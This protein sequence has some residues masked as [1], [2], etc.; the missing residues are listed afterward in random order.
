MK[1]KLRAVQPH[2]IEH[3]GVPYILLGDPL[4]LTEGTVAVPQALAVLL[5]LCDGT[6]DMGTLQ[7]GFELRTGIPLSGSTL[8]QILSHLDEA[9]LL[10]N[11][12]F[13]Q[14]C[15]AAR[16][17]FRMAPCRPPSLA[18]GGY[19]SDPEGLRALLRQYVEA[20]PVKQKEGISVP[21]RGVISPHIDFQRGG[22]VYAQVWSNAAQSIANSEMVIIFGTDHVG[23]WNQFTLTQQN[24]STP[25]GIL[26]TDG[27][28]VSR[29]ADAIGGEGAFQDELHHR[30]EHSIELALI[31]LH[32]FLGDKS[33][34]L[35]PILCGSFEQFMGKSAGP[36]QDE[37][38]DAVVETLREASKWRRTLV[39]AAADLAHMGPAFGDHYPID[40]PGR[41][42]A[43][44]SDGRLIEAMCSADAEGFFAR[45]KE[46]KD[47]RRICGLAPIYLALRVLGESKGE[48][49]GYAH[50]P[51]DEANASLVSICGVALQ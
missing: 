39:V 36:S 45:I 2:L 38:I 32:Y 44:A 7:K 48:S 6:R 13:A 23:G 41:A 17:A 21:I 18:G 49:L 34:K 46:E 50:C 3:D 42:R 43:T 10:D 20:V 22:P 9:F 29:L 25:W 4:R 47:Q 33:P 28:I 11:E 51:A 8:E 16:Q 15:D 37:A 30:H 35:V 40:T 26:P 19:P 24:Y 27:D 12:R 1:P 31:W 5:G 14:A